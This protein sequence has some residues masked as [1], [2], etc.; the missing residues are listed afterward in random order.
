LP[1]TSVDY[2]DVARRIVLIAPEDSV[3]KGVA[4]DLL[5]AGYD[6]S[7]RS[8]PDVAAVAGDPLAV[9]LS[10]E[11]CG[12][13]GPFAAA[14]RFKKSVETFLPV[15]VAVPREEELANTP[16][17]DIPVDDIFIGEPTCRQIIIRIHQVKRIK[18]LW[19]D[20]HSKNEQLGMYF[21]E[22]QSTFNRVD[23]ELKLARRLQLSM[24][25][26]G[27]VIVPG[28]EFSSVNIPSGAVSGDFYDVFRLD[29]TH[30][31]FYV[32]DAIGHGVPAALLAVFVKRGIKTKDIGNGG[33]RIIP[34]GEVL[35]SLNR[36]IIAQN[37]SDNPFITMCY[38]VYDT[39]NRTIQVA[40]A[41]HPSPFIIRGPNDGVAL[42][43]ADGPLLG[44]FEDSFK[45]DTVELLP[46]GKILL[47]SDGTEN[48]GLMEGDQPGE[49][50]FKAS[51][52]AHKALDLEPFINGIVNQCF[53]E[54]FANLLPDDVTLV[55]MQA[56]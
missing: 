28:A 50:V 53:P 29:E 1:D 45:T 15:I 34:P 9:V 54:R 40:S 18:R 35:D 55:A 42:V 43:E 24:L 44:I 14:A 37:L 12:P 5:R 56:N 17:E 6:V 7:H 27:K 49:E 31:G 10:S 20:L 52:D 38:C 32:A 39:K 30:V 11:C 22:L 48:A 8:T 13:T 36:D 47:Y 25:P 33:Y 26:P 2:A 21:K 46:G 16:L 51:V 4:G 19:L 3:W 41:G 23:S